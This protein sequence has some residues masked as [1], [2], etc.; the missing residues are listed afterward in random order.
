VRGDLRQALA[1]LLAE[2][3]A[4]QQLQLDAVD[5]AL[6][7]VACASRP[8]RVP[9]EVKLDKREREKGTR[10]TSGYFSLPK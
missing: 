3:A 9:E 1:L 2:V 4:Q 7:R 10:R 8:V 6:A 5:L